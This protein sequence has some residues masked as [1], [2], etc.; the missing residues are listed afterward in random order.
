M[1]SSPPD[2]PGSGSSRPVLSIHARMASSRANGPG[3]RAVIWLQGCRRGC[4]GCFNPDTHSHDGRNP[5]STS[6]LLRWLRDDC[7][8]I[9]GVSISGGEPLEQAE[10][11]LDLLQAVRAGTGLS[12]LLFS[13][14]TLAQMGSVPLGPAIL[15]CL[16]VL[17]DGP[18]DASQ[19]LRR[20]LRGSANQKV[21]LLT[22]RYTEADIARVPAGEVV[23]GPDGTV[24]MSGV[25]SPSGGE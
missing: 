15:G 23:I 9:E 12:V 10:G 18:F 24:T 6:D 21:H 14:F 3:V 7:P 11:L 8:G 22:D 17:V 2:A 1:L 13:G 19:P 20:G 4:A 25:G 16:D 5:T